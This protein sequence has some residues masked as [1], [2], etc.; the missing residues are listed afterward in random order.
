MLLPKSSIMESKV[1]YDT[2]N[3]GQMDHAIEDDDDKDISDAVYL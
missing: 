2:E 1:H 3:H